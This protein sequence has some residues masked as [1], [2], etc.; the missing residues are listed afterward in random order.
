[1][2]KLLA[3]RPTEGAGGLALHQPPWPCEGFSTDDGGVDLHD[4]ADG[5]LEDT[6]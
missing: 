4:R 3:G 5:W 2:N 6:A 1:M